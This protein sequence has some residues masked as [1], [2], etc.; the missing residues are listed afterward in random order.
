MD[1]HVIELIVGTYTES[2]G[3]GLYPLS[4]AP[5]TD[6]WSV[7]T[8]EAVFA[9]A[10]FGVRASANGL[11]YL[12]DEHAGSVVACRRIAD[13]WQRLAIATT[14]GA[15]PCHLALHPDG[16][17]LAV[18]NYESGSIAVLALDPA[19]LPH[20]P[21]ALQR[22]DGSG[23]D[24]ARQQGP[25]AHWVGF[26]DDGRSLIA[27]DLGTDRILRYRVHA[28][29]GALGNAAIAYTAPGGSGPRHLLFH[30]HLP[31]AYLASEMAA[32]ITVLHR[33]GTGFAAGASVPTLAGSF[34]GRNLA[35]GMALNRAADRLYVGNRGHDSVAIFALDGSGAP[36]PIGQ[37]PSGNTSPR[38]LFVLDVVARLLVAHEGGDTVTAFTI[39]PD[40]TLTDPIAIAIPGAAFIALA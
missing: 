28:A 10:S 5:A 35:G 12:V 30:P 33:D 32:T 2:G 37:V 13:G 29:T 36:T 4:Y 6:S 18:A 22:L 3:Q 15:A 7:G 31:M 17:W 9:N 14:G 40:G 1:T 24:H 20:G 25:H 34:A 26:D 39:Q 16:R 23:P 8:P 27:V 11:L 19:G 21:M 38:F